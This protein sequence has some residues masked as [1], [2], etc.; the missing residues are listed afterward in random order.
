MKGRSKSSRPCSARVV[1]GSATGG[2]LGAYVSSSIDFGQGLARD[3][4]LLFE[5]ALSEQSQ[6]DIT[7]ISLIANLK[8][9]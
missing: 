5:S 4:A 7:I 9:R 8:R 2:A 3:I 1:D 6:L